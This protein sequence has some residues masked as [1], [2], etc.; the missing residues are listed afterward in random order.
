LLL[1]IFTPLHI[2]RFCLSTLY[3]VGLH[4]L[5]SRI[6]CRKASAPEPNVDRDAT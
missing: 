2:L 6:F 3:V 1:A 5:R 4:A